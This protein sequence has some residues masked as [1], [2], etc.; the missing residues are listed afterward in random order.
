MIEIGAK[1]SSIRVA[2]EWFAWPDGSRVPMATDLVLDNQEPR[3]IEARV[4]YESEAGSSPLSIRM[5]LAPLEAVELRD[6]LGE[7]FL[8]REQEGELTLEVPA[9][10]G[11]VTMSART[12]ERSFGAGRGAAGIASTRFAVGLSQT[13]SLST[14]I[15]AANGGAALESFQVRLFSALGEPIGVRDDLSVRAGERSEWAL[16]ELFPEASGEGMTA[17]FSAAAGSL[18]PAVR[19]AVTDLRTKSRVAFASGRPASR[20]YFPVDG[21]TAGS[22]DTFLASDADFFNAG[23]RPLE[24]RVRFLERG[25]DN[26]EAPTATLVLGPRET[27]STVDVLGSLFGLSAVSGFL[28]MVADRPD[29]VVTARRT[30][31][32][33]ETPGTAAA[34]IQPITEDRFSTRSLLVPRQ[35]GSSGRVTLLNPWN[36]P[37][38]AVLRWIDGGGLVVAE[39]AAV[40]PARGS[41]SVEAPGIAERGEAVLIETDRP[42]F[43][44]LEGADRIRARPGEVPPR[45]RVVQ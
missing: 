19:A 41:A 28:E 36:S 1:A 37:L 42:H 44:L 20:V 4:S 22:G 23:T 16:G 30:A 34:A 45:E 6:V 40:V 15:E 9:G 8:T 32:S 27:R 11:T 29:L 14:E 21:R 43:G 26:G 2:S 33:A 7:W 10:F 24:V 3:A 12:Y 17:E 25:L 31:R 38:P 5:S 13:D 35:E 18:L 39:T